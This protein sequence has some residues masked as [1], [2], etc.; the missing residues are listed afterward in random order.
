M[1]KA[2]AILIVTCTGIFNVNAQEDVR[3]KIKIGLKAGANLSNVYDERGEEF[4]A[5][6]KLGFTGGVFIPIPI[7]K[8]LG[9]QPEVL[10]SQKGFKG[11]GRL[12]GNTYDLTRTTNHIDVPLMVSIKPATVFTIMAGPQFSYLLS[13]NDKFTSG[14]LTIDQQQDFKNDNIR[15]NVMSFVVGAD[16]NIDHVVLSARANWDVQNN[17][18]DGNNTSPRYKNMW[19]QFAIGYRFY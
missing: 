12:L 16:I 8:F 18:G 19:Y 1:K 4:V 13:Q 14:N 17:G 7:G 9:V 10:Y 2:I 15:K 6:S 5:D 3:E 11:Q